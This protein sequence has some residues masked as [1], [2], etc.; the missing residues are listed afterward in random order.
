MNPSE[1][2]RGLTFSIAPVWGEA[3]SGSER[4]WDARD[5]RE[6]ELGS[7]FEATGRLETELGYGFGIRC[8]RGVVTPYTGLSLGED[9][10][11][12]VRAGARWKLAPGAVMGLEGTR[13]EGA[14][15]GEGT[16]AIEFRTSISW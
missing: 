1:S 3:G 16:N 9:A 6:L 10:G 12:T 13:Q 5:A 4:L 2:G 8:T 7:K 14:H 11:K 15:G